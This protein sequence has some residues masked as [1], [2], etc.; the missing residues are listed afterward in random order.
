MIQFFNLVPRMIL[1]DGARLPLR[2]ALV[3]EL[4]ESMSRIG[5]INPIM[6][7]YGVSGNAELVAGR[8]RLEAAKRLKW[9]TIPCRLIEH[10]E[11]QEI[12]RAEIAQLDENLVRQDLSD[13]VRAHLIARRKELYERIHP[14]TVSVKVRGGPGR[15]KTNPKSGLV[16]E[17]FVDATAKAT[18]RSRSGVAQDAARGKALGDDLLNVAGTSLDK[19]VE[20]DALAKLPPDER[21]PLID[22]AARGEQVSARAAVAAK[23]EPEPA[24]PPKAAPLSD[25]DRVVRDYLKLSASERDEFLRKI[26][27][28]P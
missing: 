10:T 12:E 1:V 18:K 7:R 19:G 13:A 2:E 25:V 16:S 6:V 21:K 24:P 17:P 8:H 9:G 14:E 15:G 28:A 11:T 22:A 27:V 20:L 26:G 5:L 23:T 3:A 4:M